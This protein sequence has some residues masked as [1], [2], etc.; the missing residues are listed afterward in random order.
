M[1]YYTPE[2]YS[3]FGDVYRGMTSNVYIDQSDTVSTVSS[4]SDVSGRLLELWAQG[5]ESS[6]MVAWPAGSMV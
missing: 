6:S 2:G 3:N 5:W 4:Y 1:L